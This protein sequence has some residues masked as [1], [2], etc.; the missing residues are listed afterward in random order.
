MEH[1]V[2]DRPA[3]HWMASLQAK[4]S[5]QL[6]HMRGGGDGLLLP[7]LPLMRAGNAMCWSAQPKTT[8]ILWIAV[9][10]RREKK[11]KRLCLRLLN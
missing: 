1:A 5:A 8:I 10:Q 7:Y 3:N 6:H 2:W 4:D 11:R 9:T